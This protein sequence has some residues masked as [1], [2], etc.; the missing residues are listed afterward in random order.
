VRTRLNIQA[1][2]LD[3]KTMPEPGKLIDSTLG[4][5]I[6]EGK[7]LLTRGKVGVN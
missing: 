2:G 1:T 6:R 7:H 4:Y 3:V 5:D